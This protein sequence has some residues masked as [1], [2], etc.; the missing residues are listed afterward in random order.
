MKKGSYANQGL[1]ERTA[2]S[3]WSAASGEN[4]Q[5]IQNVYRIARY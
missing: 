1:G 4:I 2:T 5:Y 3:A